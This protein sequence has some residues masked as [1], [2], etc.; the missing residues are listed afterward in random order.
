[1]GGMTCI[2]KAFAKRFD[3]VIPNL[4]TDLSVNNMHNPYY[5]QYSAIR[6]AVIRQLPNGLETTIDLLLVFWSKSKDEQLRDT[7]AFIKASKKSEEIGMVFNFAMSLLNRDVIPIRETIYDTGIDGIK[8]LKDYITDK[9]GEDENVKANAK[10]F[11]F[12]NWLILRL[13]AM[14]EM[15]KYGLF[16]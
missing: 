14:E 1:M 12:I 10:A 8:E 9:Y 5:T 6:E 16:F 15:K 13:P 7:A 11:N 4:S 2:K 3:F